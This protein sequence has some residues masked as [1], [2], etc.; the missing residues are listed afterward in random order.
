MT[1]HDARVFDDEQQ[2]RIYFAGLLHALDLL[3]AGGYRNADA[4]IFGAGDT[5]YKIAPLPLKHIEG[6]KGFRLP[7]ASRQE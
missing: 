1:P 7:S 6:V 3:G 2:A 5:R 4:F